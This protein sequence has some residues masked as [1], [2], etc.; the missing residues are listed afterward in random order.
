MYLG[1]GVGVCEVYSDEGWAGVSSVGVWFRVVERPE[2]TAAGEVHADDEF[3]SVSVNIP[4]SDV[5]HC[6]VHSF[7]VF[8]SR[9]RDCD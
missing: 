2:I 8:E 5:C 3:V 4:V 7:A 1:G 6:A 9:V